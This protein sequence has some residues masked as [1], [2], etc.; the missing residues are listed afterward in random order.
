M[1]QRKRNSRTTENDEPKSSENVSGNLNENTD[2]TQAPY[3]TYPNTEVPNDNGMGASRS[4]EN[5]ED[6]ENETNRT[7]TNRRTGNSR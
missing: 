6:A 5:V 2:P 7:S 3:P 1:P 4:P